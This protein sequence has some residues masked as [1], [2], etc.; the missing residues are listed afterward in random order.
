MEG[1]ISTFQN[2]QHSGHPC[3]C[4]LDPHTGPCKWLLA[5]EDGRTLEGL[6]VMP[7]G[8]CNAPAT[9]QCLM[10][11]VLAGLQWSTCL[12]YL[13]DIII[14]LG[15]TLIAWKKCGKFRS[16]PTCCHHIQQFLGIANYYCTRFCHQSSA[17][18]L[19]KM[20]STEVV[21]KF[22]FFHQERWV[23]LHCYICINLHAFPT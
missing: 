16:T 12:V 10:D 11:P 5:R 7:F 17:T 20:R 15:S 22:P 4:S 2:R 8:L 19:W 1:R 21:E 13:D 9:F 6:N 18:S 14:I 3:W 23:C